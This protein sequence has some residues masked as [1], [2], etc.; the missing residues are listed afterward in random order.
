VIT[1]AAWQ[2]GVGTIILVQDAST[3]VTFAMAAAE[4]LE[5]F[6]LERLELLAT[7][8]A[9]LVIGPHLAQAR[10][11]HGGQSV[12]A[13]QGID[14]GRS[15]ADR[16][17]TMRVVAGSSPASALSSPGHVLLET[18]LNAATARGLELA[19]RA[20]R[21]PALAVSRVSRRDGD[22][23]APDALGRDP[24]LSHLVLELAPGMTPAP[25]H[26]Q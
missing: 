2:L 1:R 21:R 4:R 6:T 10:D 20:G 23:V 11:L 18:E 16:A 7:Q 12:D 24:R 13:T 9:R 3:G 8:P 15:A 14:D 25:S 26:L 17:R 22:S 19:H 5:T